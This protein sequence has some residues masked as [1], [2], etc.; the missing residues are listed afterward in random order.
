MEDVPVFG[1]WP[2][3]MLDRQNASDK[4]ATASL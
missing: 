3:E 4:Q 2:Y 1:F